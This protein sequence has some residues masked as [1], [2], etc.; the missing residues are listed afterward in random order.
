MDIVKF[1]AAIRAIAVHIYA[2]PAEFRAYFKHGMFS[3][4]FRAILKTPRPTAFIRVHSAT[5]VS[6][7][8]GSR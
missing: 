6:A 7:R 1:R 3:Q 8:Q 5:P 4:A 2:I